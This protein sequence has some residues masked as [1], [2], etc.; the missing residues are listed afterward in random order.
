LRTLGARRYQSFERSTC[1]KLERR[2]L[3]NW[4]KKFVA[5]WLAGAA[6][7]GLLVVAAFGWDALP[8]PFEHGGRSDW[9]YSVDWIVELL[10]GVILT[11]PVWL[12]PFGIKWRSKI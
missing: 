1:E 7:T 12:A 9:D 8:I 5:L 4:Y 6:L 11:S 3:K 2:I 10:K